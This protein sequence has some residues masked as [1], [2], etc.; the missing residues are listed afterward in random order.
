MLK[1]KMLKIIALKHCIKLDSLMFQEILSFLDKPEQEKILS[2]HRRQDAERSL[3]GNLIMR[4]AICDM[5]KVRNSDIEV[6][7][8]E[9]GKPYIQDIPQVFF[10][11]SHSGHWI[12]GAFG[13]FA[14][15]IDIEQLRALDINICK[16]MLAADDYEKMLRMKDSDRLKY[17]YKCWT[18]SE[19]YQKMLGSGVTLPL[20]STCSLHSAAFFKG[21]DIDQEY[22]LSV[23]S[24]RG[25]FPEQIEF[26]DVELLLKLI[27]GAA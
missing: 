8:N 26:T 4:A 24:S 3:L 9:M 11:I 19:S 7:R 12:A 13:S 18:M 1:S 10:N 15:G 2:F 22:M 16:Q 23:C 17:F 25:A 20:A 5:L 6:S 27:K 14:V 21:Y